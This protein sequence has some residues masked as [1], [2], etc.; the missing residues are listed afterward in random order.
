MGF[1]K[2]VGGSCTGKTTHVKKKKITACC[3]HEGDPNA[4]LAAGGVP[5]GSPEGSQGNIHK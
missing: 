1:T 3:K 2:L 4:H 5:G